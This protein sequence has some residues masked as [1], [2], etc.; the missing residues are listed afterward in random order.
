MTAAALDTQ[1][2]KSW[3]HGD[4][5]LTRP[6]ENESKKERTMRKNVIIFSGEDAAIRKAIANIDE[7]QFTFTETPV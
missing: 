3:E 2:K 6:S 7:M 4:S 1:K 5:F